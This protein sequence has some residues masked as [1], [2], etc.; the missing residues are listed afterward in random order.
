MDDIVCLELLPE[1]PPRKLVLPRPIPLARDQGPSQTNPQTRINWVTNFEPKKTVNQNAAN[2]DFAS[3]DYDSY[4]TSSP[5]QTPYRPASS[6]RPTATTTAKA[7]GVDSPDWAP[8]ANVKR[9]SPNEVLAQ[10]GIDRP[11]LETADPPQSEVDQRNH[12]QLSPSDYKK[13]DYKTTCKEPPTLPNVDTSWIE[14]AKNLD[15]LSESLKSCRNCLLSQNRQ[16]VIPGRG[17][18]GAPI[19]FVFDTPALE[20]LEGFRIP[21]G[22]EAELFDNIITKGLKMKP[23]E[24]YVTALSKCPLPDPVNYPETFP[25]KACSHIVFREIELVD[26]KVVVSLGAKPS[27]ILSGMEKTKFIF[28]KRKDMVIGRARKVPFVVT[29]DLPIILEH[30]EIKRVFWADLKKVMALL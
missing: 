22:P 23:E 9:V 19:F 4:D 18:V 11:W 27:Q 15:E 6:P 29:Y 2:I 10:A 3:F 21:Y 1:L 20:A 8:K 14:Q 25:M 7:N 24:V 30:I 26:P 13:S 16:A 28:L 12:S 17:P 5:I